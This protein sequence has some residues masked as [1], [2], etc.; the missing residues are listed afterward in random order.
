MLQKQLVV[1]WCPI[2][3]V[4]L[5]ELESEYVSLP[6]YSYHVFL[7]VVFFF[8]FLGVQFEVRGYISIIWWC[9][10]QPAYSPPE[11]LKVL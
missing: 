8:L 7:R 6:Y 1:V 10:F 3:V 9:S 2:L 11:A 5:Y 4:M